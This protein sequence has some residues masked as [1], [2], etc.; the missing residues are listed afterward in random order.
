MIGRSTSGG[1]AIFS[2]TK[3]AG[4]S[5]RGSS[6]AN[7]RAPPAPASER[8]TIMRSVIFMAPLT[9]STSAA[10][11]QPVVGLRNRLGQAVRF[12]ALLV[13]GGA[14][15]VGEEGDDVDLRL[16]ERR[17]DLLGELLERVAHL[18]GRLAAVDVVPAGEDDDRPGLA[19]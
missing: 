14:L 9:L 6:S 5:S 18:L 11:A 7:E 3:P 13:L 12:L 16:R 10:L 1:A 4:T 8:T 2:T 19:G 17:V 15:D